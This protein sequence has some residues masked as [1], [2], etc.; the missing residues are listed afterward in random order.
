MSISM[1]IFDDAS[2]RSTFFVVLGIA[3]G[4]LVWLLARNPLPPLLVFG[5]LAIICPFHAVRLY[6]RNDS[7]IG[8]L[9]RANYSYTTGLVTLSSGNVLVVLG[10]ILDR[11]LPVYAGSVLLITG[12]G[13][14]VA[15]SSLLFKHIIRGGLTS[16]R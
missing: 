1:Y 2:L 10:F 9:R 12:I 15:A 6:W 4:L 13:L 7:M 11:L 8:G 14:L 16:Q 5:S 3:I